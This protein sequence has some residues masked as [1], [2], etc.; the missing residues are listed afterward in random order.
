MAFLKTKGLVYVWIGISDTEI[1]DLWR[2]VQGNAI[3][4][5]NWKTGEPN[6]KTGAN[7]GLTAINFKWN[8]GDCQTKKQFVTEPSEYKSFWLPKLITWPIGILDHGCG[9]KLMELV[10]SMWGK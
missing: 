4:Y 3:S 5:T 9:T 8:D 6:G 10:E 2:D 7:C 1:E